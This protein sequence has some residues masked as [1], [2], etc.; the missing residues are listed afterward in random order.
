VKIYANP[1]CGFVLKVFL[2]EPLL[3]SLNGKLYCISDGQ[4]WWRQPVASDVNWKAIGPAGNAVALAGVA[5][6]LF[7][8][9]AD[10]SLWWRDALV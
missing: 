4:L 5:G 3:A 8:A 6:K 9:Q 10:N 2:K 1:L 7:T